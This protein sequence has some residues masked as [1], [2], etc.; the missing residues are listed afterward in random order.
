MPGEGVGAV[1]LKPLARARADGDHVYGIIRG[2]ARSGTG[3][4]QDVGLHGAR[5]RRRQAALVQEALQTA[6]VDPRHVSYVE[7]HGTGTSLGDPIEIAG[8]DEVGPTADAGKQFCAIGSVKSNIGHLEAA[9]GVAALTKVLLQMQ[10]RTLVPSIHSAT[11]NPYIDFDTSPFV[12][13]R[14]LADWQRPTVGKVELPR[15]AGISSF[16]AGGSN[17]HV[18]VEEPADG[19]RAD[20]GAASR[21]ALLVL[22]ARKE[23]SLQRDGR[24]SSP[25]SASAGDAALSLA[26]AAWT[27][28]VGREGARA[29]L[30]PSSPRTPPTRIAALRAYAADGKLDRRRLRRAARPRGRRQRRPTWR[31]RSS[32]ATSHAHRRRVGTRG[33]RRVGAAARRRRAPARVAAEARSSSASATGSRSCRRR[34]PAPP[35]CTR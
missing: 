25:I 11:L 2:T 29:A 21:P 10:H 13:Q 16:G 31:R 15:V 24:G 14:T 6:G 22:S 26:D 33:R 27:L 18:V 23:T 19:V 17:A 20:D 7:A 35:R 5:T 34:P 8:L 3:R 30:A 9:A 32:G 4:R 12:V 28:Q 1:L